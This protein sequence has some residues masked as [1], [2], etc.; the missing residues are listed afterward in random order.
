ME[1]LKKKKIKK[2]GGSLV[3][4]LDKVLGFFF[5]S[6]G[7]VVLWEGLYPSLRQGGL[8]RGSLWCKSG[9]QELGK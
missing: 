6:G 7:A 9:L 4:M 1:H 3:P 5:L 2:I 8:G